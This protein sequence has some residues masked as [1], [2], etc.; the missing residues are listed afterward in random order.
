MLDV[1]RGIKRVNNRDV[2]IELHDT[3]GDE[4]LGEYRKLWY[5]EADCFMICV[6]T[7]N[8]TSFNNIRKWKDEIQSVEPEVPIMIVLTKSDLKNDLDKPV[9][10]ENF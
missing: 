9:K 4:Y 8:W 3:S 7:D 6:A 5:R 1:Y 2:E 10:L